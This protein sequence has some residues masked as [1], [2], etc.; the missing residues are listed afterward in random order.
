M[1][2]ELLQKERGPKDGGKE[3]RT[4]EQRRCLKKKELRYVIYMCLIPKVDANFMYCKTV[5]MKQKFLET[6]CISLSEYSILR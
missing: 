2:T 4:E 6:T 1:K 5:L 3:E